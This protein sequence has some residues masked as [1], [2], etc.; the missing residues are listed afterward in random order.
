VVTFRVK[1]T[2]LKELSRALRAEENGAGLRKDLVREFRSAAMP[3]RDEQRAGIKSMPSRGRGHAGPSLR[4]EIARRVVVDVRPSGA[5]AGVRIE[6]KRTPNLRGF[7]NAPAAT[8]NPGGWHPKTF[9]KPSNR[10]QIGKPGW[11][12]KPPLRNRYRFRRAASK[13]MDQ[14]ARRIARKA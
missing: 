10:V 4:S 3:V 13:A 14:M 6:A 5:N 8:N 9:G 12:K 1:A 11:F 7:T 2:G